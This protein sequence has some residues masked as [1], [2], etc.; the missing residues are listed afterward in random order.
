MKQMSGNK[1]FFDTNMLVYLYSDTEPDKKNKVVE[2]FANND[3]YIST[4]V[5]NE[6]SNTAFKKLHLSADEVDIIIEKLANT[7]FVSEVDPA[8]IHEAIVL[9]KRYGYSYYDCLMIASAH[10]CGCSFLVTVN[11]YHYQI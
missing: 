10:E 3:H 4:Q 5:L 8:T 7:C 9:K 11:S 6:F 2:A 1:V